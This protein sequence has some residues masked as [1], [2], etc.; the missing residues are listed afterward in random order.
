MKI[1]SFSFT[2][3][4]L[5]LVFFPFVC[6]A[7]GESVR[8]ELD[9]T[10]IAY[11]HELLWKANTTGTNY[12]ESAVAYVDGI[13][14]I[15]SC[16]TH[17]EGHDR[18]FAVDTTDGDILWSQYTG[19]GYV[20][21]VIDNDV[22][23]IGSCTHGNDPVNE[24]MFAFNRFTG[25]QLWK[26]QIYG[27]IAESIQY[28]DEQMYFSTFS[29]GSTMYALDKSDGSINWTVDSGLDHCANKPMLKDNA[30]Y[31]ASSHPGGKLFKLNTAD[32]SEIWS[33]TLSARPW[34]NSITADGEG[35]I[36][37]ALYSDNTMNAYRESD[38]DLLWS[39]P[40]H[41]RPLSF[42]AY[43]N[44][45]V[46]IA[47]TAGYV[48][49]FNAADGLLQ[50]ETKIGATVD[51]SSP[52]I[53]GGLI[54]V[55]TR[56]FEDGAFFALDEA[57]G[58][59]LWKYTIGASITAPPSIADGMMMC[60]ADDW[61]LYAFDFGLGDG[62]WKLHRYDE[63]N[64]AYSPD[65]LTTWQYV[66]AD[67]TTDNGITICTVTNEYDHDV[68]A[69]RLQVDSD[70]YWHTSSGDLLK[71]SSDHYVIDHLSSAAS[72][73]FILAV[74]EPSSVALLLTLTS[75]A[76]FRWRIGRRNGVSFPKTPSGS[77]NR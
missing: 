66:K 25:D 24:Y 76:L 7:A 17:G 14:Y 53:S 20:G 42:N 62:D 8:I 19:P 3:L 23:Y 52:T 26:T 69:I 67:C 48:Y 49:A 22:V 31:F 75:I 32:G 58:E 68:A 54:F 33:K 74:P 10:E 41:D 16:S 57:T 55:G 11:G 44:G 71:P 30:I 1:R 56:D 15:G 4:I 6:G 37:L 35:R 40:L 47:D 60:G 59:I 9:R 2:S 64:S 50:W 12:E 63:W 46:Y 65:G 70:V 61:Y 21:P 45:V 34:D 13:A 28:D 36:F 39:Y 18:I 73:T 51:I 5:A 38:G 72:M 29:H 77:Y 27:G 43:H